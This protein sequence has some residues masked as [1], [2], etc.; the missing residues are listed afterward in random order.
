MR[1][2]SNSIPPDVELGTIDFAE[3]DAIQL[4]VWLADVKPVALDRP[5]TLALLDT[6]TDDV[7][8]DPTVE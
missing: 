2:R 5:E 4:V 8:D 7:E 1:Q 6:D 3:P